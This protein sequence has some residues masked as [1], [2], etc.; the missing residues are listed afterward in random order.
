[1]KRVRPYLLDGICIL[2]GNLLM[3][4]GLV[5]FTIPNNLAPGGVSGLATA[6]ARILP[7]RIGALTLLLNVPIFVIGWRMFGFRRMAANGITAFLFSLFIDLLSPCLPVYTQDILLSAVFGGVFLGAGVGVIFTR[8]IT[9]GGTDLV[10]MLL[11][12]PFPQFP[13]GKMLIAIDACVIAVAVLIFRNISVALYS[14]VTIFVQGKVVDAIMQG[15]DYAKIIMIITD[16]PGEILRVL[17]EEEGR[18]VTEFVVKGGYTRQHKSL[19]MTVSR[20]GE[21]ARTMRLAQ[22]VD[23]HAFIILYN[24]TEVHGEGFKEDQV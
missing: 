5:V 2:T 3:A 7:V 11:H 8:G 23:P 9:S 16:K 20:R 6:L 12:K 15:M 22:R 13:V 10:A 21:I 17:T 1:M 19:L 24:A 18:G 14:A 4:I